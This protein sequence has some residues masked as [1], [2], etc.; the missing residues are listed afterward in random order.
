MRMRWC[1]SRLASWSSPRGSPCSAG[2]IRR[3]KLLQVHPRAPSVWSQ[4][5][6][7]ER[8][9]AG[10]SGLVGAK[11]TVVPS[12]CATIDPELPPRPGPTAIT[13]P[14]GVG[15]RYG[16]QPGRA[17]AREVVVGV[18]TRGGGGYA[19]V[20]APRGAGLPR[21]RRAASRRRTV[22]DR[23]RRLREHRS[24]RRVLGPGRPSGERAL[25]GSAS[26]LVEHDR[27]YRPSSARSR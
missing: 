25:F 23:E 16:G 22:R 24:R 15:T 8:V 11:V 10:I 26:P 1:V 19:G 9:C 5:A 27:A 20:V 2:R 13:S 7:A 18:G 6:G 12:A 14:R 21:C 3:R 17:R 4:P